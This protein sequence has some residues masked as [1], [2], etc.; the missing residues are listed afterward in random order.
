MKNMNPYSELLEQSLC[1]IEAYSS[2]HKGK[3]WSQDWY[4]RIKELIKKAA[5]ENNQNRAEELIDMALWFIVDS[6]PFDLNFAPSIN[7]VQE[8]MLNAR[9]LR[10]IEKCKKI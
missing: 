7:L 1:E 5:S 6:G 9:R 2:S 4:T 8:A 3:E 10:E